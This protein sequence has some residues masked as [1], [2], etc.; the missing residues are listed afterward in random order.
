MVRDR[1]VP[2]W[3]TCICWVARCHIIIIYPEG[4]ES[5]H[6]R[7]S[8]KCPK[9]FLV[10]PDAASDNSA[11][12][13]DA[14]VAAADYDYDAAAAAASKERDTSRLILHCGGSY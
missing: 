11:D 12:N 5:K 6:W 14:D 9:S 3:L 1:S 13:D 8:L 4:G 7:P 2:D 10:C